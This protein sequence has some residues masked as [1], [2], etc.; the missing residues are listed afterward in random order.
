MNSTL[1]NTKIDFLKYISNDI[2]N[3]N[4]NY[5]KILSI[6]ANVKTSS[7]MN[8]ESSKG[9]DIS[10]TT[11]TVI[12]RDN[13]LLRTIDVNNLFIRYKNKIF[14]VFSD[15]TESEKGYLTCS[16]ISNT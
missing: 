13:Q 3:D 12:F 16:I 10:N 1:L 7:S 8:F 15:I 14:K 6:Y 9:T 4:P 11:G 2:L 5:I